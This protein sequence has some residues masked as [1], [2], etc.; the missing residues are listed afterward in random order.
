MNFKDKVI[1]ITGAGA[2]LGKDYAFYF[3]SKGA[4]VVVNDLGVSTSGE[5]NNN[6]AA[7]VVVNEISGIVDAIDLLSTKLKTADNTL[8]RI[9]NETMMKSEITN[10]SYFSTRRVSL[11]FRVSYDCNITQIKSKLLTIA[12]ECKL[13]LNT[14]EPSVSIEN[15]TNY[16]IELNLV[17]WIKTAEAPTIKNTLQDAIKEA[18]DHEGIIGLRPDWLGAPKVQVD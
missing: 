11:L 4:K 9:P 16:A 8:I 13:V 15:F 3:A 2:G 18:F 14:P 6:K 12:K 5:G 1:V 10:L 7:D 17:V